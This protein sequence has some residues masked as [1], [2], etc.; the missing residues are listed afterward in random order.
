MNHR[1]FPQE[2]AQA[3]MIPASGGP[4]MF[5]DTTL[6]L[7]QNESAELSVSNAQAEETALIQ[8]VVV[9]AHRFPRDEEQ[10]GLRLHA[11]CDR[12]SFAQEAE[13]S[14][15]RGGETVRGPSIYFAR[16]ALRIWGNTR[17]GIAVVR[18]D[19]TSRKIRAWVLDLENNNYISREAEFA[20]LIQRKRQG[21]QSQWVT[22]DER[23][24]REL[25]NRLGS[26]EL[27]NAILSILPSY[28]VDES[29]ERCQATVRKSASDNVEGARERI[30]RS[31]AKINI[32]RADLEIYLG[33][34]WEATSA[35]ELAEL[36]G[37]GKSIID[38]NST[39]AEYIRSRAGSPTAASPAGPGDT[40]RNGESG[41]PSTGGLKSPFAKPIET[42]PDRVADGDPPDLLDD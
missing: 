33:H 11:A 16:E 10:V 14:F 8:A 4:G 27:R 24:L 3:A 12:L 7:R 15:P 42:D 6:G 37:V 5:E 38:G 13:W 41:A 34:P 23:D 22:P 39:W 40:S 31:F 1:S 35:E 2:A 36:R 32:S 9:A 20:K 25:T 30:L 17:S 29:I 28:L 18:D 21:G 19:K 26:I